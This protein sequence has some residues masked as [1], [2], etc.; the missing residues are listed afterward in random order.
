MQDIQIKR[1]PGELYEK[2]L[3]NTRQKQNLYVITLMNVI[4]FWYGMGD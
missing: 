1:H 2:L 4:C 3:S